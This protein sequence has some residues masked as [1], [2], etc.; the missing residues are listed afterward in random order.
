MGR[1]TFTMLAALAVL[2]GACSNVSAPSSAAVEEVPLGPT[3]LVAPDDVVEGEAP[4]V[5]IAPLPTLPPTVPLPTLPPT[6]P[7]PEPVTYL[8]A[9]NL[10]RCDDNSTEVAEAIAADEGLILALGDL[11]VDGS[12]TSIDECLLPALGAALDRVYAVPGDRDVTTDA[13][14]AFYDLTQQ[15]PTGSTAGKGWFVTSQGGW[16]IIGLNSRCDEI[17]GCDVD[18]EQYQWLDALLRD[19]P[20]ECR[21]VVWHDARFS[22]TRNERDA[23]AMGALMGRI[24]GAGA[25]VLIT[26]SPGNYE[27]LGP[28]RPGGA[29]AAEDQSGIMHFNIGSDVG[30]GFEDP[31]FGG[32]QMRQDAANGYVR[33]IFEPGGYSWEFVATTEGDSEPDIGSGIC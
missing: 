29:V 31:P 25:D 5:T 21:A 17:G 16:Q 9:G 6:V 22:S 14:A 1:A 3:V 2:A 32:S 11:S 7:P 20:A 30:A 15:T 4:G 33:F 10:G 26:G 13:G 23:A 12:Q 18:S 19:E 27:R 24:D 8:A 28:L